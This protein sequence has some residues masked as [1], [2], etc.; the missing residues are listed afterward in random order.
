LDKNN[1][2]ICKQIEKQYYYEF[3]EKNYWREIFK[4]IIKNFYKKYPTRTNSYNVIYLFKLLFLYYSDKEAYTNDY[5]CTP[6]ESNQ[7]NELYTNMKYIDLYVGVPFLDIYTLTRIL[8]TPENG[9]HSSLTF[10]YFGNSHFT[11]IEYALTILIYKY[12][13]VYF[14]DNSKEVNRCLNIDFHLNLDKEI[15]K[16]SR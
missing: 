9:K 12:E 7:I 6:F 15:K 11:N 3:K 10:G 5:N 1:S 8:K 16:Y 13:L 4:K 2:L 14:I